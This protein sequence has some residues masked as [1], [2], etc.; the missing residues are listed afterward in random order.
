M[1]LQRLAP[2]SGIVFVVLVVVAFIPVGG[3]TPDS[4]DSA[5]KITSFYTDNHTK[6]FVAVIL[7]ALGTLF[8]ALFIA[9]LRDRL[10]T[11][12]A[13]TW[14]NLV[15]VA[16]AAAVAGFLFAAT[17]HAALAD[18]GDHHFSADAMVA[19]NGLDS[20]SFF[21]FA[22]PIGAMVLGAGGA[23]LQTGVLP[24]WLGWVAVALGILSFT[25]IGFI[26][27]GLSGIWIIVVSVM[28]SQSAEAA[29][30]AAPAAG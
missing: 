9:A 11:A 8:L 28:L 2:L 19:I 27:F 17:V 29:P 3:S 15:L 21:A 24:R 6:E 16:G 10:R 18:G 30:S 5:A 26:A 23:A 4:S 25:P 13:E 14:A 22:L 7:I 12:G 1:R 20:N